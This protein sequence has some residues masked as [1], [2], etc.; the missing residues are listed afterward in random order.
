LSQ[1][2]ARANADHYSMKYI[3]TTRAC[4]L[5]CGGYDAAFP[6]EN[7]NLNIAM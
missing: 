3:A 7:S 5:N 4:V 2:A 1:A 6:P